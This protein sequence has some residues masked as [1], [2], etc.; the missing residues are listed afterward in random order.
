MPASPAAHLVE[1]DPLAL[2][3]I[4]YGF[5]TARVTIALAILVWHG[6]LLVL[7]QAVSPWLLLFCSW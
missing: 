3:R 7:G 2:A 6:A 5:M 1:P 4:W